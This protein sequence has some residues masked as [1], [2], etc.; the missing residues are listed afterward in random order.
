MTY[1]AATYRYAD[2]SEALRDELRP[3]HREFLATI[4]GLRLGG[5]TADEGSAGALLVF[6]APDAATVSGWLDRDPFVTAGAVAQ[7]AVASWTVA[8]GSARDGW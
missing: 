2:A 8:L 1:F 4:D 5:A 7:R 3:A 6:E